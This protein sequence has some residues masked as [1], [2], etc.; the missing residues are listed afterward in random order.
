MEK[1]KKIDVP[2]TQVANCVLN[3]KKLS[4]KAKGMFAYLYSKPTGWDFSSH[5]IINDGKDRRDS[6]MGIIQ[7]LE[8]AG[9][10]KRKKKGDR[11]M[12][13]I[14]TY[15]PELENPTL[16]KSEKPK[17]GKAQGGIIPPVSNKEIIINKELDSNK[18]LINENS[19]IEKQIGEVIY[20]FKNLNPMYKTWFNRNPVRKKCQELLE[21]FGFVK[22]KNAIGFAETIIAIEFAPE[23]TSP[24]ELGSKWGKL[25]AYYMKKKVG[26]Q[27]KG[28]NYD[29]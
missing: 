9:Y 24:A 5:R 16:S 19:P 18:E 23:I 10:L 2:F 6:V 4:W 25:Q 27:T 8:K 7:E 15:N 3:D 11:K 29:E 20:L 13:Y 22:V 28:K 14:L 1:L 26:H 12:E 21:T 17:V